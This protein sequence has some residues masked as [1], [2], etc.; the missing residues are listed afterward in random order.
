MNIKTKESAKYVLGA[1]LI[2]VGLLLGG[3]GGSSSDKAGTKKD[4]TPANA[5]TLTGTA[6]VGSPIVGGT[7]TAKC[8]DGSGFTNA[9][10]TQANG[11]WSGTVANGALPCA[12]QVTGGTPN[13][14]LHSYASQ[15]GVV[16]VTPLTDLALALATS[17]VPSDWFSGITPTVTLAL[18]VS[19]LEQA[20]KDANFTLPSGSFDPFTTAFDATAANEWDQ[21]L[22]QLKDAIAA[23]PSIVD[24]AALIN[25]IK[26]GNLAAL[27]E[28]VFGTP[29]TVPAAM[30]G[31][32]KFIYAESRAGSGITNGAIQEFEVMADN[33]LRL[34]DGKL[35]SNPVSSDNL[36]EII[37]LD[38][39]T[40]IAYALSNATTGI[41]NELNISYSLFGKLDYQFYGSFQPFNPTNGNVPVALLDLAGSYNADVFYSSNGN[42]SGWSVGETLILTINA[43]TGVIDIAGRY[44]IDPADESFR[45]NDDTAKNPRFSPRYEVYY[46]VPETSVDLKLILHQRPGE[47][48]NSW[49][50]QEL[51]SGISGLNVAAEITPFIQTHQ[52]YFTS[53]SANLPANLTLISQ[54]DGLIFGAQKTTRCSVYTFTLTN[55]GTNDKPHLRYQASGHSSSDVYSPS[56]AAYTKTGSAVSLYW[57]GFQMEVDGEKLTATSYTGGSPI[58]EVLT[59]DPAKIA[60]CQ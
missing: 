34:P 20:L 14:T 11:T 45:W 48:L 30:V 1:G 21:L 8:A 17:S 51:G 42:S 28:S 16:N 19:G 24:H 33:R 3:C 47:P 39:D 29:A 10:T 59:N 26:D 52:D 36:V 49:R 44:I 57:S 43:N 6:A 22:E 40:N 31:K 37:W 7:L 50:I 58:D 23:D 13:V 2:T 25:L 55:D 41:I 32:K 54:D 4:T 5:Q 53:L 60:T 35:L 38:S 27:P 18:G 9:V 46:T 12:L 56:S 15:A